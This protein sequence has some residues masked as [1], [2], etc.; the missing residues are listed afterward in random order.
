MDKHV[1]ENVEKDFTVD[2]SLLYATLFTKPSF[3][4]FI[5][6]HLLKNEGV[7]TDLV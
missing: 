3:E 7:N 1:D 6:K 5:L 2:E 4:Q